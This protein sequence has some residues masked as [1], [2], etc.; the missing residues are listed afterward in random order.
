MKLPKCITATKKRR[1]AFVVITGVLAL[2]IVFSILISATILIVGV[3]KKEEAENLNPKLDPSIELMYVIEEK[4][5]EVFN[6]EIK[7]EAEITTEVQLISETEQ[8]TEQTTKCEAEEIRDKVKSQAKPLNEVYAPGNYPRVYDRSPET[9][10]FTKEEYDAFYMCVAGETQGQNYVDVLSTAAEILN[11]V[12]TGGFGNG[13]M[14][15]LTNENA[16]SCYWD[17]K[18]HLGKTELSPE[19]VSSDV[20]MAVMEA[21]NGADPTFES[22][23]GGALYHYNPDG[24]RSIKELRDRK[25]ISVSVMVGKH[26]YY[27]VWDGIQ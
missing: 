26:I 27:R 5:E 8:T 25:N 14:G 10:A 18:F 12:E 16:Y 15:V 19:R 21:L 3:F 13:L 23:E 7:T 4:R 9:Y 6:E 22:L 17:G 1:L 2:L 11:R 24:V 20:R